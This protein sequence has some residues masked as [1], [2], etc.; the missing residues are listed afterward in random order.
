MREQTMMKI[1]AIA[2]AIFAMLLSLT[3]GALAE[4]H[5]PTVAILSFGTLPATDAVKDGL[6]D[7]L[8]S[9][10]YLNED[11][12]AVLG[13]RQDLQGERIRIFW[14]DADFHFPDASLIVDSALDLDVDVLVTISTPMTQ[15]AVN[16]TSELES[17]PAVIFTSVYNP[18]V[19]GIAESPCIKPAHVTGASTETPY[20]QIVGLLRVQ[21]PRMRTIGAIYN[22]AEFSSVYGAQVIAE[23][24]TA[25]GY[26]VELAT[27]IDLADVALAGETLASKGVEAILI[28]LDNMVH[29][30]LPALRSVAGDNDILLYTPT[31]EGA[32]FGASIGAGPSTFYRRGIY[33]GHI[34]VAHLRGEVDIASVAISSSLGI[35]M[36]VNYDAAEEQNVIIAEQV[37]DWAGFVIEDGV[38]SMTLEDIMRM[39]D[40]SELIAMVA[41]VRADGSLEIDSVLTDFVDALEMPDHSGQTVDF[42]A[43]LACTP[44]RIAEERVELADASE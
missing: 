15:L 16:A 34:L 18:Y 39:D 41:A 28:P 30:G 43:E 4:G 2:L 8:A 21:A 25:M 12:R 6:I 19:A 5:T 38:L 32:Y 14:R 37:A 33:A 10:G 31:S 35:G 36:S 3:G 23:I 44:E 24:G 13:E 27:A 7:L 22:P 1:N 11:E 20:D 26:A 42:I 9:H 29:R 40:H 17:P